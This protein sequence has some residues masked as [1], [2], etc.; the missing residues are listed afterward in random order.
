MVALVLGMLSPAARA[1]DCVPVVRD[2]WVR[3]PPAGLPMAAGYGTFE[4][5]C[6]AAATIV[7]VSSPAFEEATVHATRVEHGISRMRAVPE[8]EVAAHDMARF[9]PGGLHLM[10]MRPTGALQPGDKVPVE[11]TLSDG[12][13]VRAEFIARGM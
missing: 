12:R 6:D 4:N 2:G 13:I 7:S 8:L 1:A 11:F 3:I 9:V 5:H 10:L